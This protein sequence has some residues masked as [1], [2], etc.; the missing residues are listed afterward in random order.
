MSAARGA[1]VVPRIACTAAA[2][3]MTP[4]VE[5]LPARPET[6][7]TVERIVE[8]ICVAVACGLAA[9]MSATRPATCGVAIDVP[10]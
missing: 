5:H 8:R 10:L 2:A 9:A 6:G 7:V 4:P 3:L 1:G